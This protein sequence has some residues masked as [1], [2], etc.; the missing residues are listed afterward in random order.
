MFYV[1]YDLLWHEFFK[2]IWNSRQNTYRSIVFLKTGAMSAGFIL[3][4][5]LHV[6]N[7]S[8]KRFWRT[9]A[10]MLAL[11]F[12]VLDGMLF[13]V[14]ASWST[15]KSSL[16]ILFLFI[17]W[18]ENR[19]WMFIRLLTFLSKMLEWNWYLLIHFST[20]SKISSETWF[21]IYVFSF[22]SHFETVF[23]K[24]VFSSSPIS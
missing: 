14:V 3:S 19:F 11:S 4:G 2:N 17:A 21:I 8:L 1:T 9:S 6:D 13:P 20:G 15:F 16:I 18:N 24:K 10:N 22:I 7:I 23:L 12:N 5:K